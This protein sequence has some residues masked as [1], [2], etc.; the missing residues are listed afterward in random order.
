MPTDTP[1]ETQSPAASGCQGRT[2][3]GGACPNA[4]SEGRVFC[5]LHDP[6]RIEE[7]SKL[8]AERGRN[9]ARKRAERKRQTAETVALQT[10]AD[11]RGALERALAAVEASGADPIARA[12]AVSRVVAAALNLHRTGELE[13]E[14]AELRRLVCER[15]PELAPQIRGATA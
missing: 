14:V 7:R 5:V 3:K 13:A 9:G 12:N 1:P 11:M 8:L 2:R 15:F 4:A 6:D 10:V